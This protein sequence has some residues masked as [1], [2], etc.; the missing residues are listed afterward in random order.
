MQA[1][2]GLLAIPII[3]LN[4]VGG[5]AAA[6]WLAVLGD[7]A[8]LLGGIV[9]MA[10]ATFLIGIA[11]IPGTLF[12][13]P[14]VAAL[15]RG[16][17]ILGVLIGSIA[18]LWT[19]AIIVFWCVGSFLLVLGAYKSG[20]IWPYALWSYAIA[21]GPW[22]YIAS[23]E[24]QI[25]A[26]A[27]ATLTAFFAC[28]GSVAMAVT[29]VVKPLDLALLLTVF[30][31]PM[32]VSFL[33]QTATFVGLANTHHQK[34]D[35]QS[36]SLDDR[37]TEKSSAAS[38]LGK[39]LKPNTLSDDD[40]WHVSSRQ[41][42]YGPITR[43]DLIDAIDEG[44]LRD[45]DLVWKPGLKTW[46]T[47][48]DA[49][50]ILVPTKNTV[51]SFSK[52]KLSSDDRIVAAEAAKTDRVDEV[53]NAKHRNYFIR[54]W[55]GDLSLPRLVLGKRLSRKSRCCRCNSNHR[56]KCRFQGRLS[57]GFSSCG[58]DCGLGCSIRRHNMAGC[59]CLAV[60]NEV[61]I[62]P[63]KK[64]LGRMRQAICRVGRP[65]R[66]RA[67]REVRRSTNNRAIRHPCWRPGVWQICISGIARRPGA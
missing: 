47:I 41:Q 39:Q 37:I 19:Y 25:D 1:L 36:S 4:S 28:V 63:L 40:Q 38:S 13:M 65:A 58:C 52:I 55:Q 21:T 59:R 23:R 44:S 51:P 57:S 66:T 17:V 56:R 45:S 18:A 20:S 9:A 54:H 30:T 49:R 46:I 22:T 42:Q 60:S 62:R 35:K 2:F 53:L 12:L 26:N 7:W 48:R 14:S 31:V 50:N 27:S 43:A 5:I 3:I 8:V 16:K 15:E 32:A 6:I 11:L 33:I 29:A 67:I 10:A 24:S 64:I 61:S 34:R